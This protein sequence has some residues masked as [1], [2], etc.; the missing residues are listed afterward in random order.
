MQV[1]PF[2]S[3]AT[4]SRHTVPRV[5]LNRELVGP[6]QSQRCRPTDV[7]M[8]GDLVESV[9]VLVEGAGWSGE[10]EEIM[11]GVEKRSDDILE[12]TKFI[13]SNNISDM[14]STECVVNDISHSLQ[15][16]AETTRR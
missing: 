8:I 9:R 16:R 5:L 14:Q 12:G 6:F 1:E 10:L 15:E 11:K 4:L 13:L 2:A 7:A 3:L